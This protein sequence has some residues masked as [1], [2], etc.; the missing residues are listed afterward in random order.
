MKKRKNYRKNQEGQ[1][2]PVVLIIAA[3][4]SI[5]AATLVSLLRF[6]AI[7]LVRYS[8]TL[9][10]QE[11][12][13]VGVEHAIYAL[14]QG[15][16]WDNLPLTGYRYDQVYQTKDG[17]SYEL[18]ILDGNQYINTQTVTTYTGG[19]WGGGG[20]TTT[21]LA[22][23]GQDEYKTIGVKVMVNL[24]NST[25]NYYAVVKRGYG[26]P[27]ISKGII[28]LPCVSPYNQ[29]RFDFLDFY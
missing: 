21:T 7:S 22:R 24:T 16:N 5:F 2:L 17:N 19:R 4:L 29:N 25:K 23:Q 28:N 9:T 20:T 13:A 26:G 6:N 14:Q 1:T 10:Q 27:L 15:S 18:N 3:I 12:A 8:D 11:I